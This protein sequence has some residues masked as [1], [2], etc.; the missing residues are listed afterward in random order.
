MWPSLNSPWYDVGSRYTVPYTIY[1][2]GIGWRTD[3]LPGFNPTKFQN[4]WY[5]LWIE[6]P[7][8]TGKV[9]MLDDQHE[10]LA[11]GLLHNGVTDVNTENPAE[12]TAAQKA[13]HPARLERQPEVRHQRVPASRRRLAVA[14]PGVVGRHGRDAVL[15]AQG[16]PGVGVPLLVADGRPRPDQQRH[17]RGPQGRQEPGARAPVPQ[18]PARRREGVLNFSFTGYQQPLNAMTPEAVVKR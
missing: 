6:G 18:P 13:L 9:G 14:A 16:D 17:D 2:T 12:L 1:T 4:P 15:R 3:K 7:K 5:A 11:M 10:G 8:I